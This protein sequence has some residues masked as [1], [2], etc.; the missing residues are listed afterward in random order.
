M[1]QVVARRYFFRAKHHV[2]GL[3]A[4]WCDPHQHDYTVEVVAEHQGLAVSMV[5]DTDRLDATWGGLADDLSD[6]SLNDTTPTTTTV[7]DLSA[8]LLGVFST[9]HPA[10][11]EVTVWEDASRWGRARR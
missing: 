7:E 9:A 11:R 2:A 3:P 8:W 6:S 10:V 4:P 1:K 5:V